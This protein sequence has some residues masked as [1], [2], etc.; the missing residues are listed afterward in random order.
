M[1]AYRYSRLRRGMFMPGALATCFSTVMLAQV[2][3]CGLGSEDL[4]SEL[5]QQAVQQMLDSSQAQPGPQGPQGNPG[6]PGPQGADGAQGAD[7]PEGPAGPAGPA[8]PQGLPGDLGATGPSGLACWDRNGNGEFDADSEDINQ[9]GVADVMDCIAADLYGSGSSGSLTIDADTD[10]R[11]SPPAT[12]DQGVDFVNFTVNSGVTLTVPS[13]LVLRC[14]GTFTNNGTI[15]VDTAAGGG[16]MSGSNYYSDAVVTALSAVPAEAGVALAPAGNGE[17][18]DGSATRQG[19]VGGIGLGELQARMLLMPGIK[20]G[21]GGG[22]SMFGEGGRGGGSLVV[23]SQ[24]ALLVTGVVRADGAPG[25]SGGGGAGGILI[26]ASSDSVS[27]TASA[28]LSAKGGK[29][30]DH[31]FAAPSGGGG[32]GILHAISPVLQ[33]S[34]TNDAGAGLRGTGGAIFGDPLLAGGGGGACG[35]DGGRGANAEY[36]G[37][38][39]DAEDGADGKSLATNTDPRNLFY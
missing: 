27:T 18:A 37:M 22:A 7:G 32:G 1:K 19:G 26:L 14:T 29:G 25:I 13:G 20:A 34:G 11:S 8:G 10:W 35:G 16:S 24:G 38:S 31:F 5:E 23:L 2:Q 39:V 9:D 21:G 4:F 28:L 3:N 33:I 6:E 36:S 30:S 12:P 15:V 17:F